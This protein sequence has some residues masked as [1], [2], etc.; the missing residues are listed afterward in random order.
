[1]VHNVAPH[2]S[3]QPQNSSWYARVCLPTPHISVAGMIDRRMNNM[4]PKD[5]EQYSG[6]A[7]AV[8]EVCDIPNFNLMVPPD[9]LEVC[10]YAPIGVPNSPSYEQHMDHN[11]YSQQDGQHDEF[12]DNRH[13]NGPEV[14]NT[15]RTKVVDAKRGGG[16]CGCG[17]VNPRPYTTFNFQLGLSHLISFDVRWAHRPL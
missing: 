5:C 17:G 12:Y 7:D 9:L 15:G 3:F 4:V 1:M 8:G 10:G 16:G 11:P 14:S 13:S 6:C 2:V